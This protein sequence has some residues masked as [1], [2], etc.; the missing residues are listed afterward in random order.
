MT[1][2][3]GRQARDGAAA[4]G[5]AERTGSRKGSSSEPGAETGHLRAH[6]PLIEP[7]PGAVEA[8]QPGICE[9]SPGLAP[10][11][12]AAAAPLTMPTYPMDSA[13]PASSRG[14]VGSVSGSAGAL[15][16]RA[17][18]I[19]AL[20]EKLKASSGYACGALRRY[21]ASGAQLYL[22]VADLEMRAALRRCE[23]LAEALRAFID[24]DAR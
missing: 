23:G 9:R 8:P 24:G 7:A 12:S 19:Q 3:M 17:A 20:A 18:A 13:R 5:P 2:A 4:L 16:D 11:P 22:A 1:E 14:E 21:E 10:A 15:V 6:L